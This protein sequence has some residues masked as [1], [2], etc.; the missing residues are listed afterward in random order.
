M[1]K[2]IWLF[3][4][5][6]ISAVLPIFALYPGLEK[7][8]EKVFSNTRTVFYSTTGPSL[9]S[10]SRSFDEKQISRDVKSIAEF[11]SKTPSSKYEYRFGESKMLK[12]WALNCQTY[13]ETGV[14]GAPKHSYA[15]II[16]AASFDRSSTVYYKEVWIL[17]NEKWQVA[18]SICVN[19]QGIPL[20]T[21]AYLK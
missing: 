3:L 4:A 5:V 6:L 9:E 21:P 10:A 17:L 14:D 2:Y 18:E 16:K 12:I 20:F 1:L 15:E 11:I 7:M 13:T 8:Q 19:T